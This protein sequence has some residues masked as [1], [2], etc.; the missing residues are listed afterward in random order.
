MAGAP[1][2]RTLIQPPLPLRARLQ[3]DVSRDHG[4]QRT[5]CG[6]PSVLLVIRKVWPSLSGAAWLRCPSWRYTQGFPHANDATR[7][8]ARNARRVLPRVPRRQVVLDMVSRCLCVTSHITTSTLCFT[9]RAHDTMSKI[10]ATLVSICRSLVC[11]ACAR[12]R[13]EAPCRSGR[14]LGPTGYSQPNVG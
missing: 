9:H 7:I 1:S 8:R 12:R 11:C 3:K 10:L 2:I 4:P 14:C 6:P 5:F 13:C